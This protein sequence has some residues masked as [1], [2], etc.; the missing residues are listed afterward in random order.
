MKKRGARVMTSSGLQ[1]GQHGT[2]KHNSVTSKAK[3]LIL[4]KLNP[5]GSMGQSLVFV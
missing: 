3:R 5:K 1:Q 2:W 4:I